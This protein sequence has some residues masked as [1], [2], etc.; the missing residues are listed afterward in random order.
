LRADFY[1]RLSQYPEL[2]RLIKDHHQLVLPMELEDLRAVIEEPAALPDVQLS[3]EGPLVGD[4]LFEVQGQ[5]GALPLLQFALDQLFQRRSGHQLTLAAYQAIGGVRGALRQQAEAT[6]AA[7]P[8]DEHRRLARALF[9]RLIDPGATERDT[10]RRRATLSELTLPGPKQTELMR[11][12]VD[13]FIAARLLVANEIAGTTTIEVSHEALIREW[14]RLGEWMREAREEDIHLQQVISAAVANWEQ[15]GKPA[16]RLYRGSQLKEAQAWATRNIPS[17]NEVEFLHA[18]WARRRR[19]LASVSVIFLLLIATTGIASWYALHQPPQPPDPTILQTLQDN[20]GVGSLRWCI[21]NAPSGSTI[22]FASN[23]R[24]TIK[25]IRSDISIDKNLAI[26]GPGASLLA[27][28]S[29]GPSIDVVP[30]ASVTIS[31]LS[32]KDGKFTNTGFIVNQGNLTVTNSAFRTMKHNATLLLTTSVV[33]SLTLL[34][35][36]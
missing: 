35:A 32:F 33:V 13:A 3:F 5:P 30:H 24:G 29:N 31:G 21:N 20:N 8:S 18:S 15:R 4:L 28:S 1:D 22:K 16:D 23:V 12:T 27:I 19:W 25:L 9:V 26:Q 2:A 34:A 10:T 11:Q 17:R 14:P 6:Y 7:L 36:T